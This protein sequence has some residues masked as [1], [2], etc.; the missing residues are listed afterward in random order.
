[1][2][3]SIPILGKI[4]LLLIIISF[5]ACGQVNTTKTEPMNTREKS[6][7][8]KT[9]DE[10]K[11]QLSKEQYYVLRQKGTEAPFTGK[12]LMNKEKGVYKCAACG[13]ELFT[14]DMKFDSH[15][16][17]PS[18]DKEIAGG[19]IK[20]EVDNSHGMKRTEIMCARCGGH[21]GHLFDDGPTETGLR[22]CVN[23]LSLEF[24]SEK[25]AKGSKDATAA[26][27][28]IDT[29]T[30]GG[31]CYWCVEAVYQLL[32]GVI[33]VESGFSGGSIKNPS[34]KEVC[35]G[36]TGHAEVVQITYDKSK[37]SFEEILKVFFTVHD[38]TTLNRQGG[39]VGTQYRSVI[40]YRNEQEK[41]SATEILEALNKQKVYP[42][43]VV[44]ELAPFDKFYKAEN[45]HQDYYNQ[46]QSEPYCRM[47]IQ[48]K[49][50]KFEKLFKD[51][52]KK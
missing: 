22:Y 14:D 36:R 1:M 11:N 34:Y 20:T 27:S 44:T 7:V 12:L 41:K 43:P 15:C 17:W 10:W 31:G 13:N 21:L 40:F 39:D 35:T 25:D 8:N 6:T 49:I 18:F 47:V 30:L 28:N 32:D 52:L 26:N 51:R 42:N 23:S 50:E 16:G 4:S 46:N 24:A 29:V 19:K 45:Y 5:S 9:E 37:T 2:K 3:K 33:N 38:P 48:P